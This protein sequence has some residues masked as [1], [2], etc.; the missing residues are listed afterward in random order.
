MEDTTV[1]IPEDSELDHHHSQ[2][3]GFLNPG[4]L[5]TTREMR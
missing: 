1:D 5:H 3:V 4:A 2:L